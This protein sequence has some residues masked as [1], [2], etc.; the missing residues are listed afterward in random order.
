MRVEAF[1]KTRRKL[2]AY[3]PFGERH[4]VK[5]ERRSV[6]LFATSTATGLNSSMS[7]IINKISESNF[8]CSKVDFGKG[9]VSL[10]SDQKSNL[11]SL[12]TQEGTRTLR[13]T[14]R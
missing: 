14:P 12:D 13:D 10:N 2:I 1:Y 5:P 3:L 8:S 11:L 7:E 6:K 4:K 9:F